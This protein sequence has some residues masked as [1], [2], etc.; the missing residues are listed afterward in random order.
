M[1]STE[2]K[3]EEPPFFALNPASSTTTPTYFTPADI[4]R[5]AGRHANTV[6]AVATRL[7]LEPAHTANGGRLFT[8]GDAARIVNEIQRREREALAR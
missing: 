7:R 2:R 8:E 6:K 3:T 1:N 4:A 5:R